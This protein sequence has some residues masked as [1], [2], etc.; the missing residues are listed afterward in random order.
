MSGVRREFTFQ[1]QRELI[2]E[3][4]VE[5]ARK[6]CAAVDVEL[7]VLEGEEKEQGFNEFKVPYRIWGI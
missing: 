6:V 7:V 4:G 2:Y 3:L 5:L 1:G